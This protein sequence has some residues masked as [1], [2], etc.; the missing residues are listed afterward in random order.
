MP[1]LCLY[2]AFTVLLPCF[3][4]PF[5]VLLPSL[6]RKLPG[7]MLG[8]LF[9][10]LQYWNPR[11]NAGGIDCEITVGIPQGI[12]GGTAGGIARG[13]AG[14]MLHFAY[15]TRAVSNWNYIGRITFW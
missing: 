3:Y 5:T 11:K 2:N 13:I 10:K 7:E 15:S 12:A 8:E 6:Y 14:E 9:V 1:L 4:R